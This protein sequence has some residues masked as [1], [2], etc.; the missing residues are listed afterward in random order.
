MT[1]IFHSIEFQEQ[2]LIKVR[3][4]GRGGT[5]FV[6]GDLLRWAMQIDGAFQKAPCCSLTALGRQKKVDR[7]AYHRD[8]DNTGWSYRSTWA[9]HQA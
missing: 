8:P 3:D 2:A 9:P 4:C 6:N 7:I 5:A 1:K